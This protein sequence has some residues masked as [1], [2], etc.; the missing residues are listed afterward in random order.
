MQPLPCPKIARK[1]LA[2]KDIYI[3]GN[4]EMSKLF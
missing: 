1:I 4:G 2:K 3:E